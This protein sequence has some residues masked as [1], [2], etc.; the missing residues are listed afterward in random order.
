M[1]AEII[2]IED[3]GR[4]IVS[5]I[6]P[7]IGD[8]GFCLEIHSGEKGGFANKFALMTREELHELGEAVRAILED[9]RDPQRGP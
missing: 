5:K 3:G 4:V 6:R 7:P 1:K 8:R 2:N 9:G